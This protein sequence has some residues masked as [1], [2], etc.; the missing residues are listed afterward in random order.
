APTARSSA[1]RRFAP[2]TRLPAS[3]EVLE[4]RALLSGNGP[5]VISEFMA[6]NSTGLK[7]ENGDFSDW[8]EIQNPTA[9]AVN[10]DGYFL[11]DDSAVLNKWRVP[12]RT[13]QPGGFLVVFASGK[14]R[15]APARPHTNF[16]LDADGEYLGL[17]QPDGATVSDEYAPQYPQQVENVSYGIYNGEE[18]YFA[19]PTPGAANSAAGSMGLVSDTVFSVDRGFYDSPFEVRIA[20]ETPDAAIRYTTNGIKPTATTGTLYTGPITI[21]K[22]T[23]LRAVAF[24][25]GLI[26]SNVDTQTYIF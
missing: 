25:P 22:T 10:T 16:K 24:K 18:R 15:T 5:L 20:T 6:D 12:A 23:A 7:D 8:V 2:I 4:Q 14:D 3:C 9:A 19:T 21:D 1:A 26:A 13:I 17:I 11:T